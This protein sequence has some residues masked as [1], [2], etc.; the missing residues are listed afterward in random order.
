MAITNGHY[1]TADF[2][3]DAGVDPDRWDWWGRTPLWEA[4]DMNTLPHGGRADLPSLDRTTSLDIVQ[5]LLDLGA[6]PNPQL[7]LLPPYRSVGADRGADRILTIGATPLLR[8]AKGLDAPA[9]RLLLDAGARTDI[10]NFRGAIPLPSAG[11]LGSGVGDT[12]GWFETSDV[13]DR[14]IASLRLLLDAGADVNSR[15]GGSGQ[16]ALHGAA[17]WGWN[18]VVRFLIEQGAD[19]NAADSGGRTPLDAAMGRTGAR[20]P[21]EVRPETVALIEAIGGVSGLP[22][23]ESTLPVP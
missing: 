4:V 21:G 13:Q 5:R 15:D 23:E 9:I 18:D 2:L 6:Y 7:K 11:G 12:R 20:G 10:P 16:T 14:S 22:P 17:A 19:I 1:D 8:A 3:L